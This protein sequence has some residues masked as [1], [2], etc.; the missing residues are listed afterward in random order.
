LRKYPPTTFL[1]RRVTKDYI[2]PNTTMML[3]RGMHVIIP[4]YAIHNDPDYW[5][6]PEHYDP[7]RFSPQNASR[8]HLYAFLGFGGGSRQCIGTKF[9]ML[10][11]KISLATILK[12]FKI[13]L[14]SKTST[15]LKFLRK[16][17]SL[18]PEK[19]IWMNLEKI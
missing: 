15:P 11:M 16:R 10:Q 9:A 19:K 6:A 4:V 8:Q 7:D 1:T 2:L 13:T 18:M 3:T 14:G 5:P 12:E 17:L